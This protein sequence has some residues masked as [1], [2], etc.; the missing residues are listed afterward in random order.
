MGL[1]LPISTEHRHSLKQKIQENRIYLR[2][3]Y[4]IEKKRLIFGLDELL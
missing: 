1:H 4:E 3:H 2:E